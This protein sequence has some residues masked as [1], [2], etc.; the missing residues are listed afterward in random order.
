MYLIERLGYNFFNCFNRS[1]EHFERSNF[2][3][4][5]FFIFH[6]MSLG[7]LTKDMFSSKYISFEVFDAF[8][9]MYF[10]RIFSRHLSL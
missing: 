5:F 8:L 1:Y 6:V 9:G 10:I 3:G 7:E 2:F 4:F